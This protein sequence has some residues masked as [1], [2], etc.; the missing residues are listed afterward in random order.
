MDRIMRIESVSQINEMVVN[1][2]LKHHM[3]TLLE[4]SK[5]KLIP[6]IKQKM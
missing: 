1:E 3:I 6:V 2:K 5:V 4:P